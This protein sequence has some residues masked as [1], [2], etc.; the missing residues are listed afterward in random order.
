MERGFLSQNGGGGGRGV[1]EKHNG[2][3]NDTTKDNVMMSSV[4][5]EHVVAFG[6]NK[7]TEDGIVGQGVTS[8]TNTAPNTGYVIVTVHESPITNDSALIC[9]GPTSYAKLVTCEP[10]RKSVNFRT[11]IAP[12]GKRG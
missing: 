9:S 1:K 2:L 10:C 4:V 7:G 12:I 8:I 3:G 6:N 5:N 11:L